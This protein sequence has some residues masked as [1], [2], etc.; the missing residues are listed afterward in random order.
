MAPWKWC[1]L[2]NS[3]SLTLTRL[4]GSRVSCP[5]GVVSWGL[6]FGKQAGTAS[7]QG[8]SFAV[9]TAV[10]LP[11]LCPPRWQ[12]AGQS[13]EPVMEG[14]C[15]VHFAMKLGLP[16][17]LRPC[18]MPQLQAVLCQ[19]KTRIWEIHHVSQ[20]CHNTSHWPAHSGHAGNVTH[21]LV[22]CQGTRKA[23]WQLRVLWAVVGLTSAY[24]LSLFPH[25]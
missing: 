25:F 13:A 1:D 12:P 22:L 3:F 20:F 15:W 4:K 17:E 19:K 10:L 16:L 7:W 8:G 11:T 24:P 23:R 5:P 9:S 14:L 21:G 2:H 6:H 18:S